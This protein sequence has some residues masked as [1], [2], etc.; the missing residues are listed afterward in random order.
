MSARNLNL[1][2]EIIALIGEDDAYMLF[3]N[4]GGLRLFIPSRDWQGS[5][6]F[7][8]LSEEAAYKLSREYG[9]ETIKV[10]LARQFRCLRRFQRGV[11]NGDIARRF[12][13]TES[14]VQKLKKRL[15]AKGLLPEYE[16]RFSV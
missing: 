16:G 9:R 8:G 14:G 12:G 3:E 2:R 1:E 6:A 13:M 10:P 15:R 5:E 4:Y 7:K 11:S